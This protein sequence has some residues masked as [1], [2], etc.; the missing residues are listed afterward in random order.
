MS[1]GPIFGFRRN[2]DG[3]LSYHV[4]ALQSWWDEDKRIVFGCSVPFFAERVYELMEWQPD[5]GLS[6]ESI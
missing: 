6:D 3:R 5:D 2:E 1:G 4:V